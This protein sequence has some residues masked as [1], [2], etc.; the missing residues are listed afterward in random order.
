MLWCWCV[1]LCCSSLQCLVDRWTLSPSVKWGATVLSFLWMMWQIC[2]CRQNL[3]FLRVLKRRWLSEPWYFAN[4]ISRASQPR[5]I[6]HMAAL[7]RCQLSR[8]KGTL[9]CYVY[10][11]LRLFSNFKELWKSSVHLFWFYFEVGNCNK[12]SAQW[13]LSG[14]PIFLKSLNARSISTSFYFVSL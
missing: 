9:F 6:S 12:L 7:A 3:Y 14:P 13:S 10:V 11:C 1:A 2:S 4:G 5:T 8:S